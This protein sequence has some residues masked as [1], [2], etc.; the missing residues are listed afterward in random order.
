MRHLPPLLALACATLLAGAW[1]ATRPS[2]APTAVATE[3]EPPAE[4]SATAAHEAGA[5]L[6]AHEAHPASEPEFVVHE[7]RELAPQALPNGVSEHFD[8]TVYRQ[9]FVELD[10]DAFLSDTH[11]RWR[12]FEDVEVDL[13]MDDAEWKSLD[14]DE[15]LWSGH[16]DGAPG[17]QVL[18][19]VDGDDITGN[20]SLPDGTLYAID[21]LA[22]RTRVRD[23]DTDEFPHCETPEP[24]AEVLPAGDEGGGGPP[25]PPAASANSGPEV[26]DVLMLYTPDARDYYGG[27]TAIENRLALMIDWSNAVY[28]NSG[29]TQRVRAAGIQEIAYDDSHGDGATALNDLT[30]SGDG[31]ME[32]VF[33]LRDQTGADMVS[34][35]TAPNNVCGIAWVASQASQI[36]W[37]ANYMF[38]VVNVQCI[39]SPRTFTHELAHNQGA[40]H[41]PETSLSQGMTQA[42]IDNTPFPNSFGYIAPG[43]AF[44][45][46][47]AY[48]SSCGWCPALEQFSNQNQT[49]LG[50]AT[51]DARSNVHETL[52]N[53]YL[54]IAGFREPANCAGQPDTDGDGA[55]DA[56]DNCTEIANPS[57]ADDDEDGYGDACDADYNNDGAVGLTDFSELLDN[58]G[59]QSGDPGF[60]ALYDHTQDGAVGTPDFSYLLQQLGGSPGPSALSCAGTVPCGP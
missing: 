2:A 19:R 27:T 54:V 36:Q 56:I 59:A 41:D 15:F 37:Y 35:V 11:V 9:R 30:F 46:I 40:H 31:E 48:G 51:G 33:D 32:G 47:M 25:P 17:S 45:T 43:D 39:S 20:I 12:P 55:C 7:L 60:S 23:I 13:V 18:M 50:M 38:S 21:T 52:E 29:A 16:V 5:D 42:E 14:G 1:L 4:R 57:Q 58:L 28:A 10:V 22:G 3:P 6:A 26:I 34:L 8:R 44:R 53:T 24:A 49:Y